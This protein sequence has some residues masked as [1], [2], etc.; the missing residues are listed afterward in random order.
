MGTYMLIISRT[1]NKHNHFIQ[2][3][4]KKAFIAVVIE[5][6]FSNFLYARHQYIINYS[7]TEF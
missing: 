5:I 4:D 2:S 1:T 6:D 7:N 3:S